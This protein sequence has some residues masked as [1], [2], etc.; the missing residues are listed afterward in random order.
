MDGVA[1][2]PTHAAGAVET[3]VNPLCDALSV[4]LSWPAGAC[5]PEGSEN[6]HSGDYPSG[7][8]DLPSLVSVR[9][10]PSWMTGSGAFRRPAS[11]PP[12][13]A[14]GAALE[15]CAAA[16]REGRHGASRLLPEGSRYL[17]FDHQP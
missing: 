17:S 12:G 7:R 11:S 1:S 10:R 9:Y 5:R 14:V 8:C 4:S 2:T 3:A 13:R 16:C 15:G 6:E